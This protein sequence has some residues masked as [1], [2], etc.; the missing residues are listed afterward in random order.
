MKIKVHTVKYQR[1]GSAGVG[2]FHV[3][4]DTGRGKNLTRYVGHFYP[5][6]ND[7]G[8]ALEPEFYGVVNLDDLTQ[9][10]DGYMFLSAMMQA[11]VNYWKAEAYQIV[12]SQPLSA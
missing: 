6:E 3:R 8:A 2:F 7:D 5:R 4:F 11:T 9:P 10:Q 1:N 12:T